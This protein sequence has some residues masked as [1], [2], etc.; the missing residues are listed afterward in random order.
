MCSRILW[1]C[2]PLGQLPLA[3]SLQELRGF[4]IIH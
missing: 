4:G 1:L 2:L 3:R